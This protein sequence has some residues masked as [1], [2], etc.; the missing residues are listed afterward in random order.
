[1]S[2]EQVNS[3]TDDQETV[4]MAVQ[5]LEDAQEKARQSRHPIVYS[6]DGK[7]WLRDENDKVRLIKE[8]ESPETDSKDI[9]RA[10][11]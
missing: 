9:Q 7:L 1:M 5:A 8:L 2:D 6:K 10:K 3:K 11:S 4:E